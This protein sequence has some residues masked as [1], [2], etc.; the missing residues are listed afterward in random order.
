MC[1]AQ[2][3]HTDVRPTSASCDFVSDALCV[4]I[5]VGARDGQVE[6]IRV[7][8]QM[9]TKVVPDFDPEDPRGKRAS[10]SGPFAEACASQ[11]ETL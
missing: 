2:Y 4:Q 3:V 8:L 1:D 9:A 10:T 5:L 7:V 6:G 11:P